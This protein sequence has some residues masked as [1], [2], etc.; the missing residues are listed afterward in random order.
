VHLVAVA[1][2]RVQCLPKA[3]RVVELAGVA[4]ARTRIN[5]QLLRRTNVHMLHGWGT[6]DVVF[7][8]LVTN[9]WVPVYHFML[10]TLNLGLSRDAR[11]PESILLSASSVK[12]FCVLQERL[13]LYLV[14]LDK[15][16]IA[17][18]RVTERRPTHFVV[19]KL[20]VRHVRSCAFFLIHLEL[21]CICRRVLFALVNEGVLHR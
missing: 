3:V 10:W 17:H 14:A 9:S 7:H 5:D 13:G 11:L 4:G 21:S 2:L 15:V 20:V 16:D 12:I 1:A 6:R 18:V 8:S 19:T